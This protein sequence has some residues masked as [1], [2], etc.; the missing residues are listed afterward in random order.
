M[1][2][3]TDLPN[4]PKQVQ[5]QSDL[6]DQTVGQSVSFTIENGPSWDCT[7]SVVHQTQLLICPYFLPLRMDHPG[8][9][10][11]PWSIRPNC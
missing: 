2:G 10:L 9:V 11:V 8:I 7:C 1:N 3:M 4:H 6:L 5:P